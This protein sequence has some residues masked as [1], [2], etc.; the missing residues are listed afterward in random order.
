[1]LSEPS[2]LH[3]LTGCEVL[4]ALIT[5]SEKVQLLGAFSEVYS[6]ATQKTNNL[7]TF[8]RYKFFLNIL[9]LV[10]NEMSTELEGLKFTV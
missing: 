10:W 7:F 6:I 3:S 2:Q 1:M 4:T 8:T 9:L 5:K